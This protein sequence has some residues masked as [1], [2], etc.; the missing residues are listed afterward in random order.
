MPP[1]PTQ[2]DTFATMQKGVGIKVRSPHAWLDNVPLGTFLSVL[3]QSFLI[4]SF[5]LGRCDTEDIDVTLVCPSW[6][7]LVGFQF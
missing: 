7:Q 3:A 5:A 1:P 2:R 4:G 6:I